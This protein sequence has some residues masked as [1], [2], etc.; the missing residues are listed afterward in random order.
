MSSRVGDNITYLKVICKYQDHPY[1]ILKCCNIVRIS[2]FYEIFLQYYF[3]QFI[4]FSDRSMIRKIKFPIDHH[5]NNISETFNSVAFA[6]WCI[7]RNSRTKKH[8]AYFFIDF[9]RGW[10]LCDY[11]DRL[12]FL[13]SFFLLFHAFSLSFKLCTKRE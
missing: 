9:L 5:C 4:C 6:S 3:Q 10:K 7:R 13:T 12:L 2:L 11:D 8:A 1:I